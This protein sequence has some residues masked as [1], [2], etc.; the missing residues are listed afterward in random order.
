MSDF[1]I[2]HAEALAI[3]KSIPVSKFD[4]VVCFSDGTIFCNTT[5]EI[6]DGYISNQNVIAI[7]LKEPKAKK[8]TKK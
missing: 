2:Q 8:T 3:K 6:V 7:W 1:A 5:Q 4:N